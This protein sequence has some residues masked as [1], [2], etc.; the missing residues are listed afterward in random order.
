MRT[1]L[2]RLRNGF[3]MSVRILA[4]SVDVSPDLVSTV[5]RVIDNVRANTGPSRCFS[6]WQEFRKCYINAESPAEC[7][8]AKDD[9]LEC[10]HHTKEVRIY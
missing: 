3:D 7:K 6:F 4:Q 1:C 8:F 5:V 10:L 2:S 9:Y